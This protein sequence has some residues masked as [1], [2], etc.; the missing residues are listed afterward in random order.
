ML[1]AL[2]ALWGGIRW[3]IGLILPVFAKAKDYKGWGTGLRWIL[4]ILIVAALFVVLWWVDKQ[5]WIRGLVPS[6]EFVGKHFCTIVFVLIYALAWVLWWIWKLFKEEEIRDYPDIDAD[7]AEAKQALERAGLDLTQ[8]PIFLVLGRP[9]GSDQDLFKAAGLKLD[10]EGVPADYRR[11]N[12]KKA[13]LRVY[14]NREGVYVAIGDETSR[15]G[16]LAAALAGEQVSI[17]R[18]FWDPEKSM[19]AGALS[20]NAEDEMMASIG[21]VA[22]GA[23]AR[24]IAALL[25]EA[26]RKGRD[27]TAAEREELRGLAAQPKVRAAMTET[28]AQ[29]ATE[30][31]AYLC[32]IINLERMPW[33]PINGLLWLIP[34]GATE[35]TKNAT[36]AAEYARKDLAT[37]Q[38]TCRLHFPILAVICDME[39]APGFRTW[40]KS[41]TD[42][43][44]QQRLGQHF[45][46]VPDVGGGSLH[47][48]RQEA[49]QEKL[50]EFVGWLCGPWFRRRIDDRLRFETPGKDDLSVVIRENCQP[51]RVL[52]QLTERQDRLAQIIKRA[53]P[54]DQD[55]PPMFGGLYLAATG[56][57][58]SDQGFVAGILHRLRADQSRL[59][60][61]DEALN[62]DAAAHRW[63]TNILIASGVGI[64]AIVAVVV[65][66]VMKVGQNA[67]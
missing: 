39:R 10:V 67:S 32:R 27:M 29:R 31:L 51:F 11:A 47:A 53:L 28:Q 34:F 54:L 56:G 24:G 14:A 64:A 49:L 18:P 52:A 62:T 42:K 13:S 22:A 59:T 50:H 63:A 9:A 48:S 8:L 26:K 57:D 2:R 66:I 3:V 46:Y 16:W 30:R 35:N 1:V 37:I 6:S 4:H 7:W 20:T 60:W 21:G 45:P 33:C 55:G 61:T 38:K 65:L 25:E 23:E 58:A 17:P 44:K 12:D 15:T 19:S 41:F 40:L 36:D 43:E 5:G